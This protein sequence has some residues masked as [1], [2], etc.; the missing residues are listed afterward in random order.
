MKRL[1]I[2]LPLLLFLASCAKDRFVD[3]QYKVD[4]TYEGD[5]VSFIGTDTVTD[6][7][8]NLVV[9]LKS[10]KI[11]VEFKGSKSLKMQVDNCVAGYSTQVDETDDQYSIVGFNFFDD[12]LYY[13]LDKFISGVQVEETHYYLDK[14]K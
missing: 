3:C 4:G 13:T 7:A 11:L 12:S 14:V 9:K 2:F 5:K 8:K 10:G 6:D 1:F